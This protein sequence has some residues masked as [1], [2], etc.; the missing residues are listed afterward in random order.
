[1]SDQPGYVPVERIITTVLREGYK[2]LKADLQALEDLFACFEPTVRASVKEWVQAHDMD[3][4]L[5]YPIEDAKFPSWRVTLGMDA[6]SDHFVGDMLESST[7]TTDPEKP[8]EDQVGS[9]FRQAYQIHT[10]TDNP[11]LTHFMYL[12]AKML[13]WAN[14]S[15]F[16]S[17][18][19]YEL[20]LS[21]R[22]LPR[23]T[24]LQPQILYT[25]VLE[26]SGLAFFTV[27]IRYSAVDSITVS[28]DTFFEEERTWKRERRRGR[29]RSRPRR[30]KRHRKN[31]WLT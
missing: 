10:F 25:R 13:I 14:R 11:D 12:V 24:S 16:Q 15:N 22:E 9:Q 18:G 17:A 29:R 23:D 1:M 2:V 3:V 20:T 21:G 30:R 6:N 28:Y 27:P 8:F 26:L 19:F 31:L 4:S 7:S 5:G